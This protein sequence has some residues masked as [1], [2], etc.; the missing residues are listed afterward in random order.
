MIHIAA[1]SLV[2]EASPDSRWAKNP[3]CGNGMGPGNKNAHPRQGHVAKTPWAKHTEAYADAGCARKLGNESAPRH[4]NVT[5]QLIDGLVEL[6][7]MS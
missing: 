5:H 6:R 2:P 7:P 1:H 4:P 3:C